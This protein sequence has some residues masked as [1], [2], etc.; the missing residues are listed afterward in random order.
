MTGSYLRWVLIGL[1]LGVAVIAPAG[2]RGIEDLQW[3]VGTWK[4]E[5]SQGTVFERWTAVS[6]RTLEGESWRVGAD[7]ERR[8]GESM[9]LAELGGEIFYLP[10]PA[11]NPYPVAFKRVRLEE[12]EAVFE[13]P[14]HDF[15]QRIGYLRRSAGEMTAWIEGPGEKGEP[16]RIEFHFSRS[17]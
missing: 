4:R 5:S 10:K 16:R 6:A 15:P 8:H 3:L 17:D 12:G 9:L 1:A 2:P 14:A 7:G 13:N 11:E